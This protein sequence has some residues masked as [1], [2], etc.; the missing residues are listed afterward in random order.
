MKILRATFIILLVSTVVVGCCA[1]GKNQAHQ[2]LEADSLDKLV[3]GKTTA[4][5]VCT[6]FGAPEQVVKLS[7]GNAYIYTRSVDKG[8]AVW[9]LIVSFGNYDKQD[10]RIVFFFD[11]ENILTHYGVS[12]N[13]D[14]ASYGFPF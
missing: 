1:I 5:D 10:D 11:N 6:I 7:N 13:A 4:T 9:L 3:E 8:T 12:F 14:K 2:P